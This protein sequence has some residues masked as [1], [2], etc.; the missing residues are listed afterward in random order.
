MISCVVQ[1]LLP[2]IS[3]KARTVCFDIIMSS[4]Y[5]QVE[6]TAAC[7]N[8]GQIFAA[9]LPEPSKCHITGEVADSIV[10]EKC[11]AVL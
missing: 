7:Q 9:S 6:I 8:Y 1:S 3:W 10:G 5:T 2:N 4:D 11:M